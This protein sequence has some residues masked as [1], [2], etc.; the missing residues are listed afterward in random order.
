MAEGKR[1]VIIYADLIHTVKKMSSAK[2]GVLFMTILEYINDLDPII[3]DETIDLVFE[4]IKQQMKRD[5]KKWELIKEKRS[6]AGKASAEAKKLAKQNEQVLTNPTS[7]NT[8]QQTSTNPTVSVNGTVTVNEINNNNVRAEQFEIFWK[9]YPKKVGKK[10]CKKKFMKLKESDVRLI[11]KTIQAFVAYKPFDSY[12]HP[13]PETYLNQE[14]W[15]DEIPKQ[16]Q[17]IG[18]NLNLAA[19]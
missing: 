3:E 16:N 7:V 17:Q 6:D 5:L 2:A 1:S 13:N 4:P 9:F 10:D 18:I 12:V 15:N 19:N 11:S 8:S 14:R